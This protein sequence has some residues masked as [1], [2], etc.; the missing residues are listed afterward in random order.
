MF[1][2][3]ILN[4]QRDSG[5]NNVNNKIPR[6]LIT[7][8]DSLSGDVLFQHY[9]KADPLVFNDSDGVG[10]FL[11]TETVESNLVD[12]QIDNIAL[13]KSRIFCRVQYISMDGLPNE[14]IENGNFGITQVN[15]TKFI[16]EGER[17]ILRNVPYRFRWNLLLESYNYDLDNT[18]TANVLGVRGA[19]NL[20]DGLAT[21][22]GVEVP[23]GY[24]T[25]DEIELY[26]LS[27]NSPKLRLSNSKNWLD[28][29][30][31]PT[32]YYA[33]YFGQPEPPPPPPPPPVPPVIV[34]EPVIPDSPV[35]FVITNDYVRQLTPYY[36][37][38]DRFQG[39]LRSV[40]API[41]TLINDWSIFEQSTIR[42]V[43]QN[44]TAWSLQFYLNRL[45]EFQQG[46]IKISS[47]ENGGFKVIVPPQ[48]TQNQ[49]DILA[50][51]VNKHK[52]A[53]VSYLI[54]NSV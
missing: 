53:G 34:N 50:R 11:P 1:K 35:P 48:L 27:D 47:V 28:N 45:F 7:V 44:G 24:Q 29:E 22:H 12:I 17:F 16:Y 14:D 33:P 46:T 20:I 36:K 31:R 32:V 3:L 26:K 2:I 52:L 42:L 9:T 38:N 25:F 23:R 43:N 39:V 49:R 40:F 18:T 19:G 21:V 6:H 54:Q 8:T 5:E 37:R 41:Q 10:S 4:S 51:Y 15:S 30:L 13:F